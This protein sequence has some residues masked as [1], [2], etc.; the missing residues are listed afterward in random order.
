MPAIKHLSISLHLNFDGLKLY[1]VC[2]LT[3]TR[4]ST[5]AER[6]LGKPPILEIKHTLPKNLWIKEETTNVNTIN[7]SLWA[8]ANSMLRKYFEL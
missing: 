3:T 5:I 1:K 2:A 4:L 6:N 7:P 8:A